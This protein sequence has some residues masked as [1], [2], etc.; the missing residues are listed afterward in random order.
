MRS[1]RY[2]TIESQE[3]ADSSSNIATRQRTRIQTIGSEK[4]KTCHHSGRKS[5]YRLN[6]TISDQNRLI[7][8]DIET[9]RMGS[10]YNANKI[11]FNVT[12]NKGL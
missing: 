2:E 10:G 5:K 8:I 1:D 12:N 3:T 9:I 4:R 7:M 11:R 6:Q